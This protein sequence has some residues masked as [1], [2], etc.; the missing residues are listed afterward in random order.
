[1]R[2]AL[3]DTF[4]GRDILCLKEAQKSTSSQATKLLFELEDGN[5]IEAVHMQFEK[6]NTSL[7]ISSQV[8]CAMACSFCSTGAIG[9]KKNLTVDQITDQVVVA[10][11]PTHF[12]RFYTFFNAKKL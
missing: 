10:L 6:G 11:Q 4:K 9:F 7:C 1:M 8:G 3:H 5:K 12:A 2:D